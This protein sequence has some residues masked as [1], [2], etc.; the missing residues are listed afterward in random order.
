MTNTLIEAQRVRWWGTSYV[1]LEFLRCAP[2]ALMDFLL[3]AAPD[4]A[5]P[6][7]VTIDHLWV[8]LADGHEDTV[9]IDMHGRA[10]RQPELAEHPSAASQTGQTPALAHDYPSL[11]RSATPCKRNRSAKS[12]NS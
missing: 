11:P 10:L 9:R 7:T 3:N 5:M 8:R 12:Y 6:G 4:G 1:T 2:G